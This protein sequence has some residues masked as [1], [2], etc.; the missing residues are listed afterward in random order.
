M[1]ALWLYV[2]YY[3]CNHFLLK[4]LQMFPLKSKEKEKVNLKVCI[5]VLCMYVFISW[6][7]YLLFRV[8]LAKKKQNS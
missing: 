1:N 2:F 7:I 6:L 3:P 8:I 5:Y 4:P